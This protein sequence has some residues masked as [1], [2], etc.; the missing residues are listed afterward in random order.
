MLMLTPLCADTPLDCEVSAWS[1]WG[2]CK[3]KCGDSGVRHRT[4]YILMHPANNGAVCPP[5]EQERKCFPDNCLWLDQERREKNKRKER[6][7]KKERKARRG[8]KGRRL[9]NNRKR[10]AMC[11]HEPWKNL[12]WTPCF[13][14]WLWLLPLLTDFVVGCQTDQLGSQR[15]TEKRIVLKCHIKPISSSIHIRR[16]DSIR[17]V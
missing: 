2:L 3:G 12:N 9:R 14:L 16:S 1:P 8:R 7:E 4:R 6:R 17:K 13:P 15:W 11:S 10:S 5:L